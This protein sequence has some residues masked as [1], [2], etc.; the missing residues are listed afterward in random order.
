MSDLSL[1]LDL[2]TSDS[3]QATTLCTTL[4]LLEARVSDYE[5]YFVCWPFKREPVSPADCPSPRQ[6]VTSQLFIARCC[7]GTCPWLWCSGLGSLGWGLGLTPLSGNRSPTPSSQNITPAP[8]PLSI[9]A[10]PAP[11]MTLPFLPVSL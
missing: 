4:P 6:T 10:G 7:V 3:P 2:Q 5:Q 11:F 9:G 1:S 8:Q